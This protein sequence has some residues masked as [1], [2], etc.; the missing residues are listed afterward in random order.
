MKNWFFVDRTRSARNLNWCDRFLSSCV[1]RKFPEPDYNPSDQRIQLHGLDRRHIEWSDHD[2]PFNQIKPLWH[3]I[4]ETPEAAAAAR[5]RVLQ[6]NTA[7]AAGLRIFLCG[8]ILVTTIFHSL[9]TRHVISLC[10]WLYCFCIYVLFFWFK[11]Q[12]GPASGS[13]RSTFASAVHRR[14]VTGSA[15]HAGG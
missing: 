10:R 3:L 14:Q 9:C 7:V 6:P 4:I 2:K 15:V 1:Y 13:P 8:G 12:N 5:V 11:L